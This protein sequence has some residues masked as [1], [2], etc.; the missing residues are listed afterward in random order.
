MKTSLLVATLIGADGVRVYEVRHTPE[1]WESWAREN[2]RIV[3]ARHYTDWHRV[4]HKLA[5]FNFEI[6][7]LQARG[8]QL[9]MPEGSGDKMHV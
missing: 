8:W 7:A 5:Q 2:Q 4:E 1:G 6:T 3:E 9:V